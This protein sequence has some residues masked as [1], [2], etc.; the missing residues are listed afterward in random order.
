MLEQEIELIRSFVDGWNAG[1][2]PDVAVAFQ[3][4]VE[5]L[6]RRAATEGAY[7]GHAGVERFL[8]DT[9]EVFEL[10]VLNLEFEDLGDAVLA[11]GVIRLRARGSGIETEV[12][13]G[14]LFDFRDGLVS[15]WEDLGSREAALAAHE[16]RS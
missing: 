4:D 3:P 16:A 1:S 8:A 10:F 5:F 7:L 9:R 12:P 13:I 6:P 14:G 15:R 2:P 11:A